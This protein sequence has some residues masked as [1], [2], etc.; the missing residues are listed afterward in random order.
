MVTVMVLLCACVFC[1]FW[2]TFDDY[3]R[4][5][6]TN[7][8]I[9]NVKLNWIQDVL[10][11]EIFIDELLTTWTVVFDWWK[12]SDNENIYTWSDV[13]KLKLTIIQC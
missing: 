8:L 13:I 6:E 1:F 3:L 9:H 10:W 4:N 12:K 5:G 7:E 2:T 11:P